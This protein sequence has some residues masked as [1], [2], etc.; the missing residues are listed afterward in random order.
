MTDRTMVIRKGFVILAADDSS[1]F[2]WF[3]SIGFF[4]E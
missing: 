4:C 2:L 1:L 3:L